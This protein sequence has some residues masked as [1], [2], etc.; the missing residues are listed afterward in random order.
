V[1]WKKSFSYAMNFAFCLRA[2]PPSTGSAT[3]DRLSHHRQAQ[4]P[5]IGLGIG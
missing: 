1:E 5:S 2:Q 4:P 3:I